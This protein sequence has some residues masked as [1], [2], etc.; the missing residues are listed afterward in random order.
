MLPTPGSSPVKDAQPPSQVSTDVGLLI[1][2][3]GNHGCRQRAALQRFAQSHTLSR[4][5]LLQV[6]QDEQLEAGSMAAPRLARAPSQVPDRPPSGSVG[7]TAPDA[8]LRTLAG[9]VSGGTS[10]ST[11]TCQVVCLSGL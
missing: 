8:G 7:P 1:W 2:P 5:C 11:S 6:Q 9:R 4:G 10:C 3:D